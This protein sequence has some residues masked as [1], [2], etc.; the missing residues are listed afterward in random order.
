MILKNKYQEAMDHVNVSEEIRSRVLQNLSRELSAPKKNRRIIQLPVWQQL[1]AVV[2]VF[3]VLLAGTITYHSSMHTTKPQQEQN[4]GMQGATEYSS[5]DELETAAG[6]SIDPIGTIPFDVTKTEYV[7][8]ADLLA[9]IIYTGDDN[10]L[11]Y[12]KSKGTEDNSGIFAT[13]ENEISIKIKGIEIQL[14]GSGEDFD[15][16]LWTEGGFS[17][18]LSLDSP[19]TMSEWMELLNSLPY[20]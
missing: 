4:L 8:Y 10:R 11:T 15:L 1:T 7:L 2:A 14:K 12:R 13:Y 17:Y 20:K 19:L 9:E 6:F 5:A 16:A 18:S 3:V